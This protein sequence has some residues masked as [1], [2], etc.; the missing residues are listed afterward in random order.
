V[1]GLLTLVVIR[2]VCIEEFIQGIMYRCDFQVRLV[3]AFFISGQN[4]YFGTINF[5]RIDQSV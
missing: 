3:K 4:P 2:K 5:P 1:S